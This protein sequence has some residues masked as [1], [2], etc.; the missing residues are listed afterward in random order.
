[1]PVNGQARA[2]GATECDSQS[3][4]EI[5]E[6]LHSESTGPVPYFEG[7]CHIST[8]EGGGQEKGGIWTSR[9]GAEGGADGTV[10]GDSKRAWMG[11]E[12]EVSYGVRWKSGPETVYNEESLVL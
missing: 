3:V 4:Q 11:E 6:L 7:G 2:R 12:G 5:A 1:M 9:E 8:G 10:D